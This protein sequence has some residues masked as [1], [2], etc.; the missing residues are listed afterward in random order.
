MQESWIISDEPQICEPTAVHKHMNKPSGDPKNWPAEPK[1]KGQHVESRTKQMVV[2]LTTNL[3]GDL[4][5]SN[6]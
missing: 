5:L 6:S 4:L 1:L 2:V 3:W